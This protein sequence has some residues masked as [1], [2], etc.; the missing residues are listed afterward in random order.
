MDD[1]V[2]LVQQNSTSFIGAN[3]HCPTPFPSFNRWNMFVWML[4]L[5]RSNHLILGGGSL[6]QSSTSFLS[7]L[8]YLMI[9]ILAYFCR[10]KV[11]LLCHGWGPF[12]FRWHEHLARF[13]LKKARRSWRSENMVSKDSDDAVFCD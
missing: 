7:L 12:K 9:V 1:T 3:G 10:C 6:F 4:R 13:V 2:R 11:I 8:Y 5:I